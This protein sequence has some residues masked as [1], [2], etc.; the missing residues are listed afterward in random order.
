MILLCGHGKPCPRCHNVNFY[1][2]DFSIK[3]KI[4]N[5]QSMLMFGAKLA[6]VCDD[7]AIIFLNGQLGAGKTTLTRG[8]LQ[9]LGYKGHV[10]SPTYT[11]VESYQLDH[12]KVYHFDFYRLRD[13]HELEYMGIQDYFDSKTICLIEWPDYGKGMLPQP[14][15]SCDIDLNSKERIVKLVPHS[16]HGTSI[17]H[18]FENE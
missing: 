1:M 8:F 14:D 15:L 18:R 5:E 13:P 6:R 10:K 11:L 16:E 17:L 9:G 7:A 2:N 3:L 12:H 4:P